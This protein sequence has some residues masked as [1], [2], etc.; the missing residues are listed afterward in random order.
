[1]RGTGLCLNIC[2]GPDLIR[3][4]F[5]SGLERREWRF[6][7]TWI[8]NAIALSI[9]STVTDGCKEASQEQRNKLANALFEE[10]W[11]EHN[12]VVGVRPREELR[13]F[14]EL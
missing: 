13:P 8:A 9:S 3:L 10:V 4:Y 7:N 5:L 12:R 11:I 14:F 1:L 6:F 2:T